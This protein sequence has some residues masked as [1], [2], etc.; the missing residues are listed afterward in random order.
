MLEILNTH[1]VRWII[2]E[3]IQGLYLNGNLLKSCEVTIEGT[4]EIFKEVINCIHECNI[5]DNADFVHLTKEF[6]E[7]I[8]KSGGFAQTLGELHAQFV[9]FVLGKGTMNI[10]PY[11]I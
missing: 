6:E 4:Q 8:H 11:K 2:G 3:N 9:N 7:H 10:K 5:F 1:S